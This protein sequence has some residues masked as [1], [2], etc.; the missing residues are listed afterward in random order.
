M[1]L[2]R[3]QIVRQRIGTVN[4]GLSCSTPSSIISPRSSTTTPITTSQTNRSEMR[5]NLIKEIEQLKE[6]KN[7]IEYELNLIQCQK[8]ETE[9]E[10]DSFKDKYN[11]L[12]D[13]LS[14]FKVADSPEGIFFY[15]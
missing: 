5:E 7:Q 4:E 14:T 8:E 10:R 11:K 1:R 3:E 9:I 15:L 6:Q 13:F 12:N 2:L